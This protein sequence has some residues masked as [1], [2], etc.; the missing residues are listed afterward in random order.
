MSDTA[1]ARRASGL[2]MT[3]LAALALGF[4][5]PTLRACGV[6]EQPAS[7][8]LHHPGTIPWLVTPYLAAA[9]LAVTTAVL[10]T[11]ATAPARASFRIAWVAF[12]LCFFGASATLVG[13]LAEPRANPMLIGWSVLMVC[14]ALVVVQRAERSEG[15]GRW[16][17]M[18]FADTALVAGNTVWM[19]VATAMSDAAWDAIGIGGHVY[20]AAPIVLALLCANGMRSRTAATS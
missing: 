8:A 4:F 2:A 9:L 1:Q 7:Y 14:V 20:F 10:F 18:L 19:M 11:R 3:P 17:R 13:W 16:I 15:W 6:M 5:L 12:G